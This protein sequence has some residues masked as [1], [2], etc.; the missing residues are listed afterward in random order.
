MCAPKYW[1]IQIINCSS[2]FTKFMYILVFEKSNRSISTDVFANF[3]DKMKDWELNMVD[4]KYILQDKLYIVL[5][6]FSGRAAD[7]EMD[8]LTSLEERGWYTLTLVFT[9]RTLND[10]E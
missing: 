6:Y 1:S 10:L 7:D 5:C 4:E 2:Q 3:V 9:S 8:A